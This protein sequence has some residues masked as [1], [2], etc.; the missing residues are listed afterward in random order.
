MKHFFCARTFKLLTVL[1]LFTLFFTTT[2][3][4]A[5]TVILPAKDTVTALPDP[6]PKVAVVVPKADNFI[7]RFDDRTMVSLA[8][9]RTPEVTPTMRFLSRNLMYGNIGIPAGLLIGGIISNDRN[10]RENAGYVAS[11]TAISF[12]ATYL[13]KKLVGRPRPFIRNLKIVP[14]Y[15]PG[16]S[17]FPSGHTSTS[18]ST[19]MAVSRAYPKWY[20]IA[21]S[22]LWAGATGY[23]R[24]YLGVHYPTDVL[25]GA[26]LGTGTALALKP[27]F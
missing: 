17:S 3:L 19:A 2:D 23:S 4:F 18:F 8:L 5:Q 25:G 24:M 9:H 14:V 7:Q 12:V 10:M 26:V 15:I 13:I 20:V 16:E 1:Q 21:P 11:S 22:F 27:A 6:K